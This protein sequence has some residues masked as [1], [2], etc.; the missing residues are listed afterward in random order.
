VALVAAALAS[1]RHRKALASTA[2][3]WELWAQSSTAATVGSARRR[4]E[5]LKGA[6]WCTSIE[7]RF[8]WNFAQ[9][10]NTFYVFRIYFLFS[11]P[12]SSNALKSFHFVKF[13]TFLS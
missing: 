1:R 5:A 11:T 10:V 6:R 12:Y 4:A 13:E 9:R 3:F 8:E 7:I 2:T